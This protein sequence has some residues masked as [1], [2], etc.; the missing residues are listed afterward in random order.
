[1]KMAKLRVINI[2]NIFM[3]YEFEKL[4]WFE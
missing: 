1:M 3:F 4:K 2:L